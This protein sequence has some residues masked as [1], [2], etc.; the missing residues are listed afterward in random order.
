MALIHD[1]VGNPEAERVL[2]LVHGYGADERDLGALLPYLDPEGNFLTVLPRG[3]V[4]APPGFGWY[5]IAGVGG[6]SGP[7]ATF[8]ESLESLDD[9]LDTVCA[10]HGKDRARPRSSPASRRGPR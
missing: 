7:D 10:E 5:D 9:L 8:L 3:P 4:A 2:L 1:V 6:G